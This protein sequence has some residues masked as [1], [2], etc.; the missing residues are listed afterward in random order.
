MSFKGYEGL[1]VWLEATQFHF[2][3]ISETFFWFRDPFKVRAKKLK[4]VRLLI[5]LPDTSG[6]PTLTHPPNNPPTY[7]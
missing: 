2:I 6:G 1:Q 7:S 4:A 3:L 5:A